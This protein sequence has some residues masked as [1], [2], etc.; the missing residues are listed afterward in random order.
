MIVTNLVGAKFGKL[1]VSHEL[2]P[3]KRPNGRKRRYLSCTCECGVV[4]VSS[5]D[6]LRSGKIASCGCESSRHGGTGSKLHGVWHRIIQC[7]TDKNY[8]AYKNYGGRGISVCKEW[9]SFS[10]FRDWALSNGYEAGL[11]IDRINNDGDYEP[12]N[13]RWTTRA[14]Q[15]KNKRTNVWVLHDGIRM[16][17]SD[18]SR[19]TGVSLSTV[20]YRIRSGALN[21]A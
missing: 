10:K 13:C 5:W 6:N 15:A 11:T 18:Y 1:T 2:P 16:I 19:L 12:G 20:L 14:E 7:C 4:K 3:T 9:K 21:A 17:A 8:V